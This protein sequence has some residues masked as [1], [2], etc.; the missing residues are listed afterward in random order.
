MNLGF[1]QWTMS[2]VSAVLHFLPT[3]LKKGK[4]KVSSG[5]RGRKIYGLN[6]SWAKY[7]CPQP[8]CG[9]KGNDKAASPNALHSSWCSASRS[10]N[11]SLLVLW[12]EP[13]VLYMYK[14]STV[15]QNWTPLLH[16]LF[17]K[18]VCVYMC[19]SGA[20]IG[21]LPGLLS[22]LLIEAEPLAEPRAHWFGLLTS[23]SRGSYFCLPGMIGCLCYCSVFIGIPTPVLT[24][25]KA[26]ISSI[27]PSPWPLIAF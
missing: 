13:K 24:L 6:I 1:Q 5:C 10:K 4:R 8:G 21:Y 17:K 19:R 27:E 22:S 16:I 20:N 12:I 9:T 18:K 14:A 25:G 7:Q 15:P 26:C 2:L 23:L 3:K 11:Y